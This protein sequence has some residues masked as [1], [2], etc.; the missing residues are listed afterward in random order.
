[1]SRE[2]LG[3][4]VRDKDHGWLP[5]KIV[6]EGDESAA[7]SS[8]SRDHLPS[9][10]NVQVEVTIPDQFNKKELRIIDVSSSD[11][12][13]QTLPLQNINQ[14]GHLI[15]VPD[16]C[17]L[18]SL[19][20]AAILYNLKERYQV[21]LPYTRVGDI[22]IAMNPFEWIQGLYSR[23]QQQLYTDAIL[24][25]SSTNA[26]GNTNG[27]G[28]PKGKL[29]P[30]LYE[31]SSLAYKGLALDSTHQSILVSGESGA[32]K[33]ES[34]K[35]IMSH[36]AS[37]NNTCDHADIHI[38]N[39]NDNDNDDS[40]DDNIV[41]KRV[42]DSNPL[43]EAF[44]NAKTLRNDNSSRFGKY[45]Q[46]QFDVEDATAAAYQGKRIPS[47]L[48]VGSKCETYLLE[49]SRVVGHEYGERTYHIFYQLL[50]APE[51]VKKDI[52]DGLETMTLGS[53]RYVGETDTDTTTLIEDKTDGERWEIT[54]RALALIGVTGE[55]YHAL[56]RALCTVL[57]LGNLVVEDDPLNEDGSVISSH[58]EELGKLSDLMGVPVKDIEKALTF[59]TIHA[60]KDTYCVPLKSNMARDC[61]DA[62]AKAIYQHA[63]DWL[64]KE[65]NH[66]TCAERN[67]SDAASIEEYGSI[68]ILD[69][70]G[71]ETFEVNRFEQFSINYANEKLQQ[72][73]NM[74]I[75]SSVQN[76]YDYEGIAMPE[77]PFTD[78]S[79]V[80]HLIEGRMGI[81]SMLNEECLRPHGNDDSFVAKI[82]TVNKD[83]DCLVKDPLQSSSQFG[84]SHF[85][86]S[87]EYDASN[88][89]T[90]NMDNLPQDLV[91]CSALSSNAI[92]MLLSMDLPI[93][94]ASMKKGTTTSRNSS[95]TVSSKFRSQLHKLMQTIKKTKTRYVRCIKPNPEKTPKK[96][97][98][99]SSVEQLRCAGVV[100][101]VT[102]SRLSFPNRLTHQIALDRFACI[103]FHSFHKFEADVQGTINI[104]MGEILS[105][106]DGQDESFVCGKTRV[107]FKAGALEFLES[108]RMRRL[109]I[110]AGTIQKMIRGHILRSKYHEL[111]DASIYLQSLVRRNRSQLTLH[112]ARK[113]VTLIS[114]RIRCLNAKRRLCYLREEKASTLIQTRYVFLALTINFSCESS[115]CLL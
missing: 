26:N 77:V 62:F 50:S 94:N 3:V 13:N 98:L 56:M 83:T 81:I 18:P 101:A 36:L 99:L 111:R 11:Y 2:Q 1:M 48:M 12:P 25:P 20:E 82:K 32:G 6:N 97:D 4:Y 112:K 39:A 74:D 33:T 75:F 8:L 46:L 70:F 106:F 91:D 24:F 92:I 96:I 69:I 67:Y 52:W 73:Y 5:G 89:V 66:A 7:A 49:K 43:L 9:T 102:I 76:E 64:V 90:K 80:L 61:R 37:V 72:K 60:A 63:F 54:M 95:L 31:V 17:D 109:G 45:I 51:E 113:A 100:A 71:Y 104:L 35:I 115:L 19:H 53:F 27:N 114:C 88:F 79:E 41:V 103:S 10:N 85:A 30:H 78:N 93:A 34:V 86:G 42:L 15:V 29:Q 107:Y 22:I 16:M 38:S 68:A 65:I 28:N 44:G 84:I 40:N 21:S 23:Q 14:N 57:Q 108:E 105:D 87:V 58:D 110:L 59:R 47:C 55:K